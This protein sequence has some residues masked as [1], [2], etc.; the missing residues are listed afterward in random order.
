[1]Q[2]RVQVEE[3][4]IQPD[5]LGEVVGLVD[6]A[7]VVRPVGVGCRELCSGVE[8]DGLK[9]LDGGSCAIN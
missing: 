7:V 4:S 1:M 9:E 6:V 5:R 2:H 3:I 8:D